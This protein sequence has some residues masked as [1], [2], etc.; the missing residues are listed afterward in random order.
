MS[1]THPAPP[2]A[3]AGGTGTAPVPARPRPRP[4]DLRTVRRGLRRRA[5]RARIRTRRLV[6]RGISAWRKSLHVRIGAITMVVAG[7]VVVI[8]S[9]VLFSQIRTQLLSVKEQAAIDQAQAGVVYARSEVVGIAAGDAASVRATLGRTVNGL[10]TRGGSAGDFDVVMVY[11]TGNTERPPAI[12]RQGVYPA[13]PPELRAGV[14]GGGQ[15]TQYALVPDD[16]G[17][18]RPTLLVGVPVP[19]DVSSPEEIELYY[20]FPL[21]Q[22]EET[23]SLIRSTV[24][25]SG[26]A[27]TLFV[28]G[29]GVLVT[30]LVVDPVRRAAGT[31]QRLAEGQL[32]ERMAVRGE[33]DLARLATS[34]NAMAD[35]LQRQITQL[36]G[37]SQLQQR[38]TSDVSHELRTPLTT[39]QMAA[40]VLHESRGDFPPHVARSAELLHEELDRFERLLSDLLEISRYD[41]GAAVLDWAPTDLGSLVGRV[42][43]GMGSLAERHGCELRVTGP[44]DPVIAE[45]DARRV[46]RILRNLVGNAVEHGSGRPIEVT[47]AANRTAAAVTVRDHGVGLSSA[48]AQHVFDRF[49]R[50][51]PSR[52]R[53]VGGSGLGLSISL[54]D[55][56]LHGGWLQVWG[57]PG[58]GAQFRLTVPLVAGTDLTSSPLPL[59]PTIVRRPGVRP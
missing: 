50:A 48:E 16:A 33:D 35:S 19:G 6:G 12:S 40:D 46:E 53:T 13:L 1:T 59:R 58:L 21:D 20:A 22:E 39:V 30:R 38:F 14:Q 43:D 32:E 25:I 49:W 15:Y 2:A 36:E 23:L 55:A 5:V 47:L 52:V 11:R 31:A 18:P 4:R 51:D 37:L 45:V 57:Q 8:V 24:A 9:L 28:A 42:V 27:L 54:E 10:L 41:A 44:A 26:I 3:A 34:F 29:I 7:T 56:R 17:E